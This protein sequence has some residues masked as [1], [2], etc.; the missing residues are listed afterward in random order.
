VETR[1]EEEAVT[2]KRQTH[3]S[4]LLRGMTPAQLRQYR[5]ALR[6]DLEP[7]VRSVAFANGRIAA[8]DAELRRRK[9]RR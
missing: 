4:L 3:L 5:A 2:L 9:P 7:L 6:L 8:I 1:D